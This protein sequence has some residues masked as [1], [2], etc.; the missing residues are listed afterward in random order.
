YNANGKPFVDKRENH[1]SVSHSSKSICLAISK[2]PLG[3]DIEGIDERVLRIKT[4]YVN[5]E[6]KKHYQYNS[7]EDLTILWTI[8]E[9]LYKLYDIKGLSFKNDI[10]ALSRN[11]N[12]HYFE[13]QTKN[14]IQKHLLVHEKIDNEILTYNIE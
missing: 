13:V 14:G 11:K 2:F 10:R 5:I 8:K 12:E 3:I 7:V 6:D 1:I 4:K 9:C